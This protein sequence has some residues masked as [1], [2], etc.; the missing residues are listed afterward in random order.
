MKLGLG[1][2][3]YIVTAFCFLESVRQQGTQLLETS[4]AMLNRSRAAL[5]NRM[6]KARRW[7]AKSYEKF[8]RMINKQHLSDYTHV[9]TEEERKQIRRQLQE[10]LE[11]LKDKLPQGAAAEEEE[12]EE[13]EAEEKEKTKEAERAEL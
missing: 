5:Y 2:F 9:P 7:A 10:L 6:N 1:V 12:G 4:S 13:L 8:Q 3:L 11:K